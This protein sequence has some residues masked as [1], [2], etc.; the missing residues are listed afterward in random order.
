M[1]QLSTS[2]KKLQRG[3]K[4]LLLYSFNEIVMDI[5]YCIF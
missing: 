4:N 1:Q 2:L 3:G 5:D